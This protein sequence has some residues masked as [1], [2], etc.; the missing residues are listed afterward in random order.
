MA[1]HLPIVLPI[2]TQVGRHVHT[3]GRLSC[4]PTVGDLAQRL[5]MDQLDLVS[6]TLYRIT[7]YVLA[8]DGG[9]HSAR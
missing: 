5:I 6:G 3:L 8:L 2:P 7:H 1:F 4:V 9:S